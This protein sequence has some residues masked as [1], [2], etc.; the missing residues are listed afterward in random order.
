MKMERMSLENNIDNLD[1]E[2]VIASE[3]EVVVDQAEVEVKKEELELNP[4]KLIAEE[5][6][7][8]DVFRGRSAGMA[9]VLT[10]TTALIL[11][12]KFAQDAHAETPET[13]VTEQ[14]DEQKEKQEFYSLEFRDDVENQLDVIDKIKLIRFVVVHD[15]ETESII[16][17]PEELQNNPT[18]S[19]EGYVANVMVLG[20]DG[21]EVSLNG[22][23]SKKI[24]RD[25]DEDYLILGGTC[26]HPEELQT[27]E[28]S[29]DFFHDL[30]TKSELTADEH[31][32]TYLS[33]GHYFGL[34][35]SMGYLGEPVNDDQNNIL[36]FKT[37]DGTYSFPINQ[38]VFQEF[39]PDNIE[40]SG[41]GGDLVFEYLGNRPDSISNDEGVD[42]HIQ[43][44]T[45][46]ITRVESISGSNLIDR[47]RFIDY[48]ADNA[49]AAHYE[50][51]MTFT[52]DHL[53]GNDVEESAATAEH[54]ILHK[55]V[56]QKKF[57]DDPEIRTLFADLKGYTSN[58]KTRIINNG[59]IPFDGFNEDYDNK[60]FFD[61]IDEKS[62]LGRGGGHSKDNVWEF[63]TSFIHSLMYLDR[64]DDNLQEIGDEEERMSVLDN[65]IH[66][67]QV[68]LDNVRNL[69]VI[70]KLYDNREE[71]FLKDKLEQMKQLRG[72]LN[73]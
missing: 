67:T 63:C 41:R 1:Q 58:K 11:G 33:G 13:Q 73:K 54:E 71:K 26:V 14:T 57:T 24:D 65:Y 15:N 31:G 32:S 6:T 30:I 66:T 12:S 51:E 43:A 72:K 59:W 48:N 42:E 10:L 56:D 36:K 70:G 45:N 22:Q 7:L 52:M 28:Y 27:D 17:S 4:E 8:L 29:E 53:E 55:Y 37:N 2:E 34:A 35:T 49:F 5:K 19:V 61:F 38:H 46:A 50:K 21:I 18:L 3:E 68:V 23:G 16:F 20:D 39:E 40:D 47:V 25:H 69:P 64:L 9:K 62:F 44:I 60:I